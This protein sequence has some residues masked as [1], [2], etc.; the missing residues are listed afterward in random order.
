MLYH[1]LLKDKLLDSLKLNFSDKIS[2]DLIDKSEFTIEIPNNKK[3]GDVS[4][5]I[6]M[7]F[8]KK[9][10]T[11]PNDLADKVINELRKNDVIEKIEKVKPGFINIFF[12]INFWHNQL[13]VLI[14]NLDSYNYKIKKKKICLEFV[15]ANPT[16]LMHIGHARGAVLGDT[17]S[18]ILKE[19]G[20]D[21]VSEYYIN[22]A[23]EQIKVLCNTINYHLNYDNKSIND[24]KNIYPGEYLKEVSKKIT[25]LGMKQLNNGNEVVDLILR[26]IKNDLKEINV[27]H[28]N[29]VSEKKISDQ[30]TVSILQNKLE[31]K[32]LSYYGYQDK[33][34][35]I[36]DDNWIKKKTTSLQIKKSW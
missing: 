27:E 12:K 4:T 9:L 33:P 1:D 18:S 32:K 21:V 31:E 6:A 25:N 3:F 23:G 20:H 8:S 13:K 34:K 24:L 2:S 7:V 19:V 16:G 29:F 5:N 26:D 35:S 10:E 17:I 11:T 15:S 14:K 28:N 30:K 36:D 22:D